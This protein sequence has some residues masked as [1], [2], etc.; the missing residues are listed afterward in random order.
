MEAVCTNNYFEVIFQAK[1]KRKKKKKEMTHGIYSGKA[2]Q[3]GGVPKT[4]KLDID[5]NQF[6]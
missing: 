5:G 4:W 6:T 3:K 1:R 2:G